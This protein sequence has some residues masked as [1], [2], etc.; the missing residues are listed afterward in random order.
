MYHFDMHSLLCMCHLFERC[1]GLGSFREKAF[2]WPSRD[3]CGVVCER[4]LG[5]P[6]GSSKGHGLCGPLRS[7]GIA[8]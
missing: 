7:F 4:V 2:D 5:G 8:C 3:V 6:L 1:T